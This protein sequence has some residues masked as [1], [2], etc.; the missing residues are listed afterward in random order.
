MKCQSRLEEDQKR[1]QQHQSKL[2]AEAEDL[3][4]KVGPVPTAAASSPSGSS[5]RGPHDVE[6]R[7]NSGP[8]SPI[9]RGN[10]LLETKEDDHALSSSTTTRENA[11]VAGT[12]ENSFFLHQQMRSDSCSNDGLQHQREEQ[13]DAM[14]DRLFG[15]NGFAPGGD[16]GSDFS[17]GLVSTNRP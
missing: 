10:G 8:L 15:R 5:S 11:G 1:I 7:T 13:K 12:N 3:F 4:P 6:Q 2:Q 17:N 16:D 9:E 14:M